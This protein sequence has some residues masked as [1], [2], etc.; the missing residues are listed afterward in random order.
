MNLSIE[1]ILSG[2][3]TQNGFL[4][5]AVPDER[6]VELMH[7]SFHERLPRLFPHKEYE[8]CSTTTSGWSNRPPSAIR[9]FRAPT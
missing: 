7:L 1:Q 6:L 8:R 3:R 2:A 9:A 5:V 4:D